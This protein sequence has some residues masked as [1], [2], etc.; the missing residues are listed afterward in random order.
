MQMQRVDGETIIAIWYDRCERDLELEFT[1]GSITRYYEVPF[2][3]YE[4]IMWAES[5][6][7]Y[8][9]DFIDGVYDSEDVD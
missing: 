4:G 2:G 6:E 1:D 3:H 5:Y 9:E 7:E 8:L